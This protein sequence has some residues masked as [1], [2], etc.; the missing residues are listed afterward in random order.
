MRGVVRAPPD[1][2][3]VNACGA[4]L[5]AK[6]VEELV[7]TN[8]ELTTLALDGV[9]ADSSGRIA[10]V[11][12]GG[13]SRM[14]AGSYGA[15]PRAADGP[16]VAVD[17]ATRPSTIA[18]AEGFLLSA[19]ARAVEPDA[20]AWAPTPEARPR[21][22]RLRELM[23]AKRTSFTLDDLARNLLDTCDAGA[24]R[25]LAI[26]ATRLPDHPRAR[27]L[28]EWAAKQPGRGDEHFASLTLWTVFHDEVCRQLLVDML[29]K[30]FRKEASAS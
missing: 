11:V 8:R 19:N 23:V 9:F 20:I 22:E 3:E 28:V 24:R 10:H 15:V 5:R 7:A 18:P 29:G 1:G 14:P 17:E 21:I 30:R 12:S 6:T 4:L 27:A 2:H 25:L 26:W 13:R 16:S